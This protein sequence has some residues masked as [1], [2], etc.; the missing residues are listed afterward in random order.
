MEVAGLSCPVR[1][2]LA[3]PEYLEERISLIRSVMDLALPLKTSHVF[4]P[5]GLIPDPSAM[6]PA[7]EPDNSSV[8]PVEKLFSPATDSSTT[9]KTVTAD[10]EF[11]TLCQVAGDLA[12]YG[13]HIGC[14][15]TLQLPNYD[16]PL[17]ERLTA[18]VTTGPLQ[19]VFDPAVAVFTGVSV[20][21]TYRKLYKNV[22]D[23]RARD[24]RRNSDVTG[25]ETALGDGIVDWE[26]F[27]PTLVE[28]DYAGWVCVE[29]TYGGHREPDVLNGVSRVK[30][31]L[32]HPA[33]G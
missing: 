8:H 12:G 17:I 14:T 31:L 1:H 29:R 4:V 10:D 24:G 16:V 28:A 3:D 25:T 19:I 20:V 32:P 33:E 18:A 30:S 9:P 6:Q 26:E 27:L 22:G 2:S 13:N 7:A 11:S 15:L 21:D 23:I 5:C